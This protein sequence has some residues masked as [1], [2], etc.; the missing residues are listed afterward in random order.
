MLSRIASLTLSYILCSCALAVLRHSFFGQEQLKQHIQLCTSDLPLII[1][2]APLSSLWHWQPVSAK[3]CIFFPIKASSYPNGK[4][5]NRLLFSD[6]FPWRSAA[7]APGMVL[8]ISY[9]PTLVLCYTISNSV[10]HFAMIL[11]SF[12]FR[13]KEAF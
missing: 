1:I 9:G 13:K 11:F 7:G 6:H 5:W 8:S 4:I 2:K 10:P 3:G 12:P